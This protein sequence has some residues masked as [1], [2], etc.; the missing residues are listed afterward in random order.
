M[1]AILVNDPQIGLIARFSDLVMLMGS[2]T[3]TA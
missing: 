1:I 3:E 2:I